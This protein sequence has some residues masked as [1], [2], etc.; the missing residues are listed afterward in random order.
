[1]KPN[2]WDSGVTVDSNGGPKHNSMP[3]PDLAYQL[4]LIRRKN[5]TS[6]AL[7]Y[8]WNKIF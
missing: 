1:M 5:F 6:I 4:T 8:L 7:S 3:F 2:L